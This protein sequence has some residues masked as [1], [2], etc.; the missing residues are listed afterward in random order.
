LA[1]T[2][3]SADLESRQAGGTVD[4]V[5]VE[6]G[7]LFLSRNQDNSVN[8]VELSRP[9]EAATNAPGGILFLLRSVTNAVARLLESTNQW[10]GT[11]HGVAFT[12]CA[13]HLEDL[14]NS[15]PARLDLSD[16]ALSSQK[17][18]QPSRHQSHRRTL[19]AVEHQRH[20]QDRSV[21]FVFTTDR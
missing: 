14:V 6:G 20:H 4:S 11:I 17:Y 19:L 21:R 3:A 15:R 7:K 8:V 2:G 1:V 10:S 5:T 9:A 12:N 18:F 13:L 16:I